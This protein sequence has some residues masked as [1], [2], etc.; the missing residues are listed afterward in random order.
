M[1]IVVTKAEKALTEGLQTDTIGRIATKMSKPLLQAANGA[2]S[3]I[4]IALRKLYT[5]PGQVL[6]GRK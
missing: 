1:T 5:P 3:G 6:C 2:S 4:P